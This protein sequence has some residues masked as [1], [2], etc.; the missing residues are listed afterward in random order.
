MLTLLALSYFSQLGGQV[1]GWYES[2][3]ERDLFSYTASEFYQTAD[4]TGD[5]FPDMVLVGGT[6]WNSFEIL[7][8]I[9]GDT[10][11]ALDPPGGNLEDFHWLEE[12]LTGDGLPDL[13]LANPGSWSGDGQIVV[14]RGGDGQVLWEVWGRQVGDLFGETMYLAD[15]DGDGLKDVYSGSRPSSK[16]AAFSGLTGDLLWLRYGAGGKFT[17]LAPDLDGDGIS[18]FLFGGKARLTAVSGATGNLIWG[19]PTQYLTRPEE[20]Q[21]FYSDLNQDGTSDLM[22]VRANQ[23]IGSD[24]S[25]GVIEAYDGRT[26]H[27]LWLAEGSSR[28][29]RLGLNAQVADF[30]LD[31]VADLLSLNPNELALIDGSNGAPL[32]QRNFNAYYPYREELE[33]ADLDGDGFPEIMV[34]HSSGGPLRLEVVQSLTGTSNWFTDLQWNGEEFFQL[35][36]SDFDQDG[37][38]DI[39]ASSPNVFDIQRQ[40]GLVRAFS[41]AT[42]VELWHQL[43]AGQASYLGRFS[44]VAEVDAIPGP[45]LILFDAG[46]QISR[47]RFAVA[48]TTGAEL[49][50][51]AIAPE[52]TRMESWLAADLDGDGRLDVVENQWNDLGIESFLGFN[53]QTGQQIWANFYSTRTYYSE[54]DRVVFLWPDLDLDGIEEVVIQ[55]RGEYPTGAVKIISGGKGSYRTGVELNTD[56][57]SVSNGGAL[58]ASVH[59]PPRQS[60]WNY[61]LLL[62][63]TGNQLND[64]N[65]LDVPLSPGYWLSSTF[66]GNYPSG[67]FTAPMGNLNNDSNAL[68]TLNALPNQ[69]APAFIGTTMYLA[70]ISAE[71][72]N[73]WSFSSGSAAVQILP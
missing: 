33:V 56:R 3:W 4:F 11:F 14:V 49:W 9:S 16:A 26:G 45:D 32:W 57:I 29:S 59:F 7:D 69:I 15:L 39:L 1:G 65:G 66:T 31:G 62:S 38:L 6:A 36:F 54:H 51:V 30:N 55:V 17:S 53:S 2:I 46:D 71:P 25:K 52:Y 40:Q 27:L 22:L 28:D 34:V 23:D 21:E 68:I 43:G 10:W 67:L 64:L 42:G 47:R 61:Q 24:Y 72:G 20:W 13:V 48:G 19:R 73:P 8:G 12:D 44:V 58:E 35:K 18:D 37:V 70:V 50:S 63:E 5:G 41:G 60:G